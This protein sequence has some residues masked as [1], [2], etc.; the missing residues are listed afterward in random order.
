MR[1]LV[2]PVLLQTQ[3]IK[4][5]IKT[6]PLFSPPQIY[7]VIQGVEGLGLVVSGTCRDEDQHLSVCGHGPQLEKG[8]TPAPG[9]GGAAPPGAGLEVSQGP[10]Q[11]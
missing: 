4:Y 5:I 11:E 7:L 9:Q 8:G 2:T 3:I 10:A 1:A 6:R